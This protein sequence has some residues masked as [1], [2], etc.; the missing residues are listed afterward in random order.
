M[1]KEESYQKEYTYSNDTG[2]SKI[3][4]YHIFPG[5]EVSY[6]SVH[7]DRFDFEEIEKGIRNRYVGIHYCK[8]GRIEQESGNEFF[9]LMPG[10]CSVVIRDRTQKKFSVPM[11][12]Y[13]GISIGIDINAIPSWL[14]EYMLHCHIDPLETGMRICGEKHSAILRSQSAIEQ[15]M[16]ELYKIHEYDRLEI[17]KFKIPELMYVLS[18]IELSDYTFEGIALPRSQVELVK[19]IAKYIADNI[20]KKIT[21]KDLTEKFG[22]SNTYLQNSFRVMYGMPVI[23]FIRAQKMQCA[24]QVLIHTDRSVDHIAE[25][26]GY[27]NESKFSSAFKKIM[28]DLPSVYRKEHSKIQFH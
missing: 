23:S 12:H 10:D 6:V 19:Q 28:G 18:R 9:Y 14:S 27:I 21:I 8:E 13:H 7:M 16:S 2:D 25:E 17:L 15:F 3:V 20:N 26:F 11:N 5:V 1:I 22:I 24:A 4:V